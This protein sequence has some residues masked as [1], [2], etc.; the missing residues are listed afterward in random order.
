MFIGF[1]GVFELGSLLC[2]VAVDS[3]QYNNLLALHCILEYSSV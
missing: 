1:L 3:S 2:G